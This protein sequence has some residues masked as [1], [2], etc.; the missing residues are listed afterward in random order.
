MNA[1]PSKMVKQAG[2]KEQEANLAYVAVTR[3]RQTLVFA[4]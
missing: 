2:Q 1:N 4:G 3:A